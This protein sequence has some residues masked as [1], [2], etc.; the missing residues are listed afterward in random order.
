LIAATALDRGF[1]LVTW[2]TQ[3][4]QTINS[5]IILNPLA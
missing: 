4:F 5:L 2:N 1:P 3:D